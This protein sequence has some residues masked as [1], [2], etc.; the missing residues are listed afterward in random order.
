MV[1]DGRFRILATV[2]RVVIVHLKTD[3]HY[4]FLDKK[5]LQNEIMAWDSESRI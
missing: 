2:H 5:S 1:V 3:S 4:Y